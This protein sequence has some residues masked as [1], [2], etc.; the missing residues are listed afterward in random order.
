MRVEG[1]G[2]G[3]RDI[4]GM[5]VSLDLLREWLIPIGG[6]HAY[7]WFIDD[8]AWYET[9]GK[10][11]VY[12]IRTPQHAKS[13]IIKYGRTINLNKRFQGY[14]REC[15]KELQTIGVEVIGFAYVEN[16]SEAEDA[17]TKAFDQ[18]NHSFADN[19]REYRFI[20]EEDEQDARELA[21]DIFQQALLSINVDNASI[22]YFAP[23]DNIFKYKRDAA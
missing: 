12:I 22:Q 1:K 2:K 6:L 8:D 20:N 23:G 17:I 10:G 9:L 16:Q 13:N 18:C 14:L 21:F 5:Y 19:G 3:S 4:Q 11:W 7:R 15:S